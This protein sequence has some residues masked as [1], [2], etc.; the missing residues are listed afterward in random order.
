MKGWARFATLILLFIFASAASMPSNASA[1]RHQATGIVVGLD[2]THRLLDVSCN[3][4]PD[5]M[6][7]MEMS[8]KV[9]DAKATSSL[10]QGMKITFAIVEEGKA[11]FAENI[12]VDTTATFEPEPIEAGGL[13]ALN[14]ALNKTTK[15]V[16]VGQSVPDFVL[17]DQT[18]TQVRL[19]Q[20]EGKV[21]ALTFG[22]SRCPNPNYCYRLSN[23]LAQLQK[24]TRAQLGR[25][26]VLLT[27]AIDPEHDNGETLSQY[28]A[29]FKADPKVWHFLTGP[30][31]DI[32]QIA[33]TFG[34]N[35]W[36]NEGLITHSLHTVIV[37][38][39]GKLAVN[40]EGN[41]FTSKQLA[42]LVQ[43]VIDRP[44]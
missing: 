5:Y 12:N 36:N 15:A 26:L 38:R 34:M 24:R 2:S 11:L 30:I 18:G 32:Q 6:S 22:Y 40:I 35:F 41:Q 19:S 21:V 14:K 16:Q 1:K 27:I 17:T 23:N 39:H 42:D 33:A 4:I 43:S 29:A 31:T 28:A 25:D 44:S 10:K 8:F 20:F 3:E 37:D 9:R 13:T 7:A